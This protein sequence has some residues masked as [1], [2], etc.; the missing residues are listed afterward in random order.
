MCN[1]AGTIKV[2][3]AFLPYHHPPQCALLLRINTC[4][5]L[6]AHA[7][8]TQVSAAWRRGRV[9]CVVQSTDKNFMVPVGGALLAARKGGTRLVSQRLFVGNSQVENY[10]QSLRRTLEGE[11]TITA[12]L[13]SLVHVPAGLS[14]LQASLHTRDCSLP[15]ELL[16]IPQ[17]LG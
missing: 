11:H 7:L 6:Q 8:C 16:F 3:V 5:L 1:V 4:A 12:Y 15:Q 9:D 10:K 14:V 17:A 2:S 13:S